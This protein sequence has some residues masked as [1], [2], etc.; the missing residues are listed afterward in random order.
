[1][2]TSP[3]RSYYRFFLSLTL[4]LLLILLI[5]IGFVIHSQNPERKTYKDPLVSKEVVRGTLYDRNGKILAIQTPYWGVFF[6]LS[7]IDDLPLVSEVVAPFVGMSPSQILQQAAKYTTYAQIKKKMDPALVP[8]LMEELSRTKLTKQVSVVK[9]MGRDYPATFHASQTIGF[10]NIDNEGSEG[11][12]LTQEAFLNPYPL[13]GTDESTYGED[14]TLTLDIDIQYLLDVQM[15]NIA[16]EHNPDYG[17]AI[18]LDAQNGDILGMSSYPWY[19]PNALARS[20]EVQKRNHVANYLFEPGSVFKVFSLASVMESGQADLQEPFLC[21]GSYTF[22]MGKGAK[23]TIVCTSP[24]G[25]VDPNTMI[26][27]SC[28]GAISHWAMQTDEDLFYSVLNRFGFN[29][30]YDIALPS[31]TRSYIA[32]PSSWSGRSEAT[33]SFGQELSTTAL[34]IATAAT[35]FTNGGELLQPHLILQRNEANGGPITYRRERTAIERVI[36]REVANSLLLAMEEATKSGGT[37]RSVAVGGVR[38]GA[39][40]GTSQILNPETN[41]YEDGTV[42]ASTLAIVPLDNPKYIIYVAAGNPKGDTQWGSNIAAPAIGK[43]IESL[44][45]QG[46]VVSERSGRR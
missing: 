45:S 17:V 20:T 18:V 30:S 15:Q 44:V 33:I 27:K 24:H 34:H 29:R 22:T 11:I 2:D 1:M 37:A 46:K 40:T 26:A 41:S 39:K 5:R 8:A 3:N 25:V 35:A 14:I 12:E 38:V 7:M 9:S 19:D 13:I 4:L 32:D 10:T 16:D 23:A 6:H 28:N 42:L 43:I 36:S 21:D 31:R